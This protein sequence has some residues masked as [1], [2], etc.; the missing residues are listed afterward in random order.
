M[1]EEHPDG[2]G[3]PEPGH[4]MPGGAGDVLPD[5]SRAGVRP[6]TLSRQLPGS[7][8]KARELHGTVSP[9]ARRKAQPLPTD[10]DAAG[11]YGAPPPAPLA[12]APLTPLTGTRRPGGS[13]PVGWHSPASRSGAQFSADAP[14]V[15]PPRHYSKAIIVTL[16]VLV[17]IMLTGATIGGFKLIDSYD[18]PVANPLARPSVKNTEPPL[19]VPPDPT[20]TVTAPVVPDLVR[21]QKNE[22]YK[23]GKVASVACK[24]PAIKP[25]S[26]SAI[27][28][29][30]RA[31]LPCLNRAWEP[32]IKKAGYEFEAPGL[33][34]QSK[35]GQTP[36]EKDIGAM[37][38]C[39]SGVAISI[40]WQLDLEN[41]QEDPLA[42][43]VWM[44]ESI[45]SMYGHH[46]QNMTQML[47][48][49]LSRQGWAKTESEKLE[50][51]RRRQLQASCLGAAFLG[52][53]KK[54]LGLTGAKLD[55]WEDQVKQ[56][57]Q[58]PKEART[59]GSP[60]NN[61]FWAGPAFKSADPASCNTFTAPA[62]KVS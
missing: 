6:L 59:H 17:V 61:W 14:L 53:N 34:L 54:S 62:G 32:L 11:D 58:D 25:N 43:R 48:A 29:Y 16:S 21:L 27:L 15:K 36:C 39:D 22:I 10:P 46:V 18:N 7:L 56:I 2:A 42:T 52:A 13:R 40:N 31:V 30:Y 1:P 19:P 8:G 20:V 33:V 3:A 44:L 50:W 60:K 12:G 37:F 4:F 55:S 38:Y 9:A 41:Y 24:E 23:A 35:Q 49:D 5:G 47:T 45:A 57:G 51:G 26:Q 28:K